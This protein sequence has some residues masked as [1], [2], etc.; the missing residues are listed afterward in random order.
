MSAFGLFFKKITSVVALFLI[1]IKF[2][3]ININRIS[4]FI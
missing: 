1:I 3:T 2:G 4:D